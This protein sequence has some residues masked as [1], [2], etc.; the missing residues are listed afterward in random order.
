[1]R[2]WERGGEGEGEGREEAR[3]GYEETKWLKRTAE[4]QEPC[5]TP[6]RA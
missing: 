4:I 1:M 2:G 5:G 3:E 6:V